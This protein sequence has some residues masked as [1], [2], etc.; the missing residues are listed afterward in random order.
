VLT[1]LTP[2][3]FAGGHQPSASQK[4]KGTIS[5][6]GFEFRIPKNYVALPGSEAPDSVF[7]FSKKY[8]EGFFV[9]VPAAKFDEI[10]SLNRNTTVAL[11]KFFPAAS[12]DY[13]WK[14]LSDRRTI[15][16]FEVGASKAMGFNN[17]ELVIVQV[18]HFR[19]NG[20][21]FF[22]GDLFKW[23]NGNEKEIFAEGLGGESMQG[24]NDLVDIVYSVTG[25]KIAETKFPCEFI[26][27][28]P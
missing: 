21:E 23:T 25:E 9:F 12:S 6:N 14:P 22:I 17:R 2:A 26:G 4:S 7:L 24:C 11:M 18:H 5:L 19:I 10:E 27:I 28:V 20:K 15:S 13:R 1:A 3:L 8:A 16:K